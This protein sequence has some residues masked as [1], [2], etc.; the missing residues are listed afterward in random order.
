MTIS[1]ELV[2][3][4]KV[5]TV[6][7]TIV[8]NAVW[9]AKTVKELKEHQAKIEKE[10]NQMKNEL[11]KKISEVEK[12]L[13]YELHEK[14]DKRQYYDDIGGWRTDIRELRRIVIELAKGDK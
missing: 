4:L 1:M 13:R 9:I 10:I 12:E 11:Q 3:W 14:V 2:D 6:V 7:A 5:F 8:G